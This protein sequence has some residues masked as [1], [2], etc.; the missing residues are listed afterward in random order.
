M[1]ENTYPLTAVINPLTREILFKEMNGSVVEFDGNLTV[2]K[3]KIPQVF[4]QPDPESHPFSPSEYSVDI[5]YS[6]IEPSVQSRDEGYTSS[7][8][9]ENFEY[10]SGDENGYVH[11]L[12]TVPSY[13]CLEEGWLWFTVQI[14]N[15][16]GFT[17]STKAKKI[18]VWPLVYGST[19]PLPEE[20]ADRRRFAVLYTPQTLNEAQRIQARS[21]LGL[22]QSGQAILPSKNLLA[23]YKAASKAYAVTHP[24]VLCNGERAEIM[25]RDNI[26]FDGVNYDIPFFRIDLEES[27]IANNNYILSFDCVGADALRDEVGDIPDFV[28]MDSSVRTVDGETYRM[29]G[30]RIS[31]AFSLHDGRQAVSFSPTRTIDVSSEYCIFFHEDLNATSRPSNPYNSIVIKNLKLEEGTAA[32][33][34]EQSVNSVFEKAKEAKEL[35]HLY[36]DNATDEGWGVAEIEGKHSLATISKEVKS[37]HLLDAT[38]KNN[39]YSS[40][41]G[42][43]TNTRISNRI[44]V[45]FPFPNRYGAVYVT[46]D[47]GL[48]QACNINK[49]GGKYPVGVSFRL[50]TPYYADGYNIPSVYLRVFASDRRYAISKNP[51]I[52]YDSAI[53]AKIV[54][55]A[56]SYVDAEEVNHR[57]FR[58]TSNIFY[59]QNLDMPT[60]SNGRITDEN[61]YAVMECN[62]F[63]GMVL[64]GIPYNKSPYDTSN[65]NYATYNPHASSG[66]IFTPG[67]SGGWTHSGNG[68]W[69]YVTPTPGSFAQDPNPQLG[70]NTRIVAEANSGRTDY[71]Q[72]MIDSEALLNSSTDTWAIKLREQIQSDDAHDCFGRDMKFAGDY[73]WMFFK[74][75]KNLTNNGHTKT[76]G[77]MFTDQS[78]AKPGDIAFYRSPDGGKWFD[79]VDHCA[80]VMPIDSEHPDDTLDVDGNI[81][82]AEVS[83]RT[84][85]GGRVLRKTSTK[86]KGRE[87]AYFAR[88]YGWY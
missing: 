5:H 41:P 23:S 31:D 13:A 60:R 49:I 10:T 61:G 12:W 7:I 46:A 44:V 4:G 63:V 11:V 83:D 79:N 75:S 80:I 78:K 54:E 29:P 47:R 26:T 62:V 76:C 3:F 57:A 19:Y 15:S 66:W 36:V 27:L 72:F 77:C 16:S 50:T 21:N 82:I 38:E 39:L 53:A 1:P 88:P 70:I 30:V 35:T 18:R 9:V 33:E 6:Q 40:Y 28:L 2:M 84:S 37:L 48:L 69:E 45:P 58:Y 17:W 85:T 51:E 55:Y 86:Y 64:R 68:T 42:T 34:F 32:T 67:N 71:E 22:T 43:L 25:Y 56:K 20:E 8:P 14:Y 59:D 52:P 81:Q 74:L 87:I 73:A 24:N 65:Q